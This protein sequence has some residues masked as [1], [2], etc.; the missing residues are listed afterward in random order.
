MLSRYVVFACMLFLCSALTACDSMEETED[1]LTAQE[2]DALFTAI[3][4]GFQTLGADTPVNDAAFGAIPDED[5]T[6]NPADLLAGIP[7]D[8]TYACSGGGSINLQGTVMPTISDDVSVPESTIN[9]DFLF[10]PSGCTVTVEEN[11]FTLNSQSGMRE[12]GMLSAGASESD[13]TVTFSV[14]RIST[15]TGMVDWK[16]EDRSGMCDID[17]STDVR[18]QIILDV[19]DFFSSDDPVNIGDVEGGTSGML[20]DTSIEHAAELDP[21]P[22]VSTV[23]SRVAMNKLLGHPGYVSEPSLR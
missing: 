5:D 6:I 18:F 17:L 2:V 12:Q 8:T 13:S 22:Q 16:L 21:D 20:C 1:M 10:A 14:K 9:Y 3:T 23:A 4:T 19:D 7:V 11:T 15:A